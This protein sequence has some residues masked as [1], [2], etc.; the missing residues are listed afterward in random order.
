M[1]LLIIVS[2]AGT[3][4]FRV[5]LWCFLFGESFFVPAVLWMRLVVNDLSG[6]VFGR[7]RHVLLALYLA[8]FVV[9]PI[10]GMARVVF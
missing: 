9:L 6:R 1:P 10:V 2:P 7:A 5:C 3:E 4:T 8:I